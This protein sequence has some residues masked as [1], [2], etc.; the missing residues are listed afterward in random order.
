MLYSLRLDQHVESPTHKS[1][2]TLDLVISKASEDTVLSV[3]VVDH[4]L[5]DHSSVFCRLSYQK[6]G[7]IRKQITYRKIKDVSETDLASDI[8]AENIAAQMSECDTVDSETDK[9]Q[10]CL[11]KLLDKHAP[12]VKKSIVLRPN[13]KWM[14]ADIQS[15]KHN[16]RRAER[17]WR[18]DKLE[19]HRQLYNLER[20]R[21]TELVKKAKNDHIKSLVS[22]NQHNPKQLFQ[23][24][25][26]L[27][28]PCAKENMCTQEENEETAN[29]FASF[30][31]QKV[32]DIRLKL[33]TGESDSAPLDKDTPFSGQQLSVLRPVSDTE[34]DKLITQGPCK[35]CALDPLP[36]ALVKSCKTPLQEP[37][38]AILNSCLEKGVVPTI[39][40]KALVTPILKKASLDNTILKNFRPISNLS[41]LSKTL[42]KIVASRLQTHLEQNDLCEIFQSA[43]KKR[44]S[45]ETALLRV[46]NDILR[47]L[48]RQETVLLVL[49]DLSAAFD[50]VDH[51]ILLQRMETTLGVT[52]TAIEWFRSYLTD[53]TLQVQIDGSVST[54]HKVTH[55]VP[56]GS[57]L[58]PLLFII[59]ILPLGNIIRD[60]N[61][62]FHGYA[63]DNQLYFGTRPSDISAKK[64]LLERCIKDISTWMTANYLKLNDDKTEFLV[65]GSAQQRAKVSD[66]TLNVGDNEIKQSPNVRNLGVQFDKSLSMDKQVQS[67]CRSSFF[68]LHT[69]SKIRRCLDDDSL[70]SLIRACVMSRLDYCNSLLN[71]ISST[72][73]NCLQRVQNSAARVITGTKKREHITPVLQKLHW[74]PVRQRIMYKTLSITFSALKEESSPLYLR[75]LLQQH[76]PSRSLRSADKQLLDIPRSKTL[77]GARSFCVAAAKLWNSLPIE[78]KAA[79]SKNI[80]LKNLK[81]FLFCSHFHHN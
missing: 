20:N 13:T 38:L 26:R 41:F 15:A 76:Q 31:I 18:M 16:R 21:V 61:L 28:K 48:D 22:N 73:I 19:I 54:P 23:I 27:L 25:N 24:A 67:V 52:G 80:F 77:M 34:L 56:Q 8:Y 45:T 74:L 30:F 46:Q 39:F 10:T 62:P 57:V 36:T 2:H 51:D 59:Y 35:T 42:E 43:Y 65:I 53:R 37:Y 68:H 29:R 5:S 6:P 69:I 64:I 58:G 32:V 40:K 79:T 66:V 63:D 71:G 49:L 17:I 3:N 12:E 1:G 78:L 60:H 11:K 75:E 33:R 70:K 55:G 47:C 50:T 72:N 9:L 81:T 7:T 4:Q 14:T 44:H